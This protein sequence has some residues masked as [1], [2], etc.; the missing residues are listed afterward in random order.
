MCWPDDFPVGHLFLRK[1]KTVVHLNKWMH[2]LQCYGQSHHRD[3][4]YSP[5]EHT[6]GTFKDGKNPL[7]IVTAI[8]GIRF[9]V[10]CAYGASDMFIFWSITH[11]SRRSVR[12]A[13][14]VVSKGIYDAR[15]RG[16]TIDIY[17]SKDITKLG[18]VPMYKDDNGALTLVRQR[19][20]SFRDQIAFSGVSSNF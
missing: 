1:L 10:G 3:L 5:R 14:T 16:A 9:R 7:S 17:S 6:T 12:L 8:T 18:T 11:L 20:D 15:T 2:N 19:M 13:W 4:R